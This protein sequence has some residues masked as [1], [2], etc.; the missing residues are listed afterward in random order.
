MLLMIIMMIFLKM[1]IINYDVADEID[2]EYYD[3]FL[4]MKS[5]DYRV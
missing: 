2:D 5:I 1:I 4:K 3:D